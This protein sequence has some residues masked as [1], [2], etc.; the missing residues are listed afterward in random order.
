MDLNDS[1]KPEAIR[2][3][4]G[5]IVLLELRN[6]N[7]MFWGLKALKGVNLKVEKGT[8]H[9]LIGPNGSGKTTLFN[10][11]TGFYHPTSGD[12]FFEDRK[13]TGLKPHG[14]ARRGI[15]RTFQGTLLFDQRTLLENILVASYC[16]RRNLLSYLF[17]K[18]KDRADRERAKDLLEK[19]GLV[20]LKD[21]LVENIPFG[22]RHLLEIARALATEPKML[23]FDE[24][25]TGLNQ[26]EVQHQ[27]EL[28]RSIR[29]R[30]VTI[31]IVEHNMKVIFEICDRISV[32]DNGVVIA[33][34]TPTEIRSNPMVIESYIGKGVN[35]A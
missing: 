28:M 18:N 8:I 19:M 24:P 4:P 16:Q 12:V 29:G 7:M 17:S 10:V 9:G 32:L 13:I 6:I 34:G 26:T 23:F 5:D 20:D 15:A 27:L 30:G 2:A 22:T 25:S 21:E 11:V 33:E 31:F 14:I 1:P 3:I 35:Y